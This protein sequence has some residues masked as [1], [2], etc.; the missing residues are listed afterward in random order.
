MKVTKSE[1]FKDWYY[2][3]ADPLVLSEGTKTNLSLRPSP[4]MWINA[5]S[6]RFILTIILL[7][8]I[9][10]SLQCLMSGHVLQTTWPWTLTTEV[11]CVRRCFLISSGTLLSIM[12]YFSEF[13]SDFHSYYS[14]ILWHFLEFNAILSIAGT[15]QLS[16][17]MQE[18]QSTR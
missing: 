10:F 9:H 2:S 6:T 3:C 12:L 4:S 13:H 5:Y 14:W 16:V 11:R 1:R 15:V 7:T 17:W 18:Q 8:M